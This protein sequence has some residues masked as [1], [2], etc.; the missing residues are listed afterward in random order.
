[1][2][3]A[4]GICSGAGDGGG[5]RA[6]RDSA[7]VAAG[8]FRRAAWSRFLAAEAGEAVCGKAELSGGGLAV[9]GAGARGWN[10]FFSARDCRFHRRS[11]C[12]GREVKK[13]S[14]AIGMIVALALAGAAYLWVGSAVPPGQEPLATLTTETSFAKFEDSFDKSLEGPRLVLLLSPT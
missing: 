14:V 12:W 10:D 5:E 2:L 9:V 13:S 4:A 7:A 6:F 1:M 8:D 3:P 11:V